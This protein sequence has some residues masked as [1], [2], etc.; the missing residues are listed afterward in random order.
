MAKFHTTDLVMHSHLRHR[1]TLSYSQV[2]MIAVYPADI[3]AVTGKSTVKPVLRG[4]P[5]KWEGQKLAA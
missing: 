2:N 1:K 3:V 4:H 5:R